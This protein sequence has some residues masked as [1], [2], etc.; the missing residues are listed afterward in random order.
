MNKLTTSDHK[1][2]GKLRILRSYRIKLLYQYCR[3]VLRDAYQETLSTQLLQ[4]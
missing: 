1:I 3:E 2:E 4:V